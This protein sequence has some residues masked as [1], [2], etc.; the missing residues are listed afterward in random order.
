MA[1]ADLGTA[2]DRAERLDAAVGTSHHQAALVGRRVDDVATGVPDGPA[3]R[4]RVGEIADAGIGK[5]EHAHLACGEEA[6]RGSIRRP[7][8]L[9]AGFRSGQRLHIVSA[10][11]AQPKL[12]D[13]IPGCRKHDAMPVGRQCQSERIVVAGA[14]AELSRGAQRKL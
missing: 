6:E 10:Q 3:W 14:A 9:N 8:G 11:I 5:H 2:L 7:E 4:G 13:A 1:V 12:R